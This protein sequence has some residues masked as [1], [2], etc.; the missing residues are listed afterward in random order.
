MKSLIKYGLAAAMLF[1]IAMPAMAKTIDV[2]VTG[3]TDVAEDSSKTFFTAAAP[4]F[5]KGTIEDGVT[6]VPPRGRIQSVRFIP[7]EA[8]L[9]PLLTLTGNAGFAT[10]VFI[11]AKGGKFVTAGIVNATADYT[12]T[13]TGANGGFPNSGKVTVHNFSLGATCLVT[14]PPAT[15]PAFAFSVTYP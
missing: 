11:F 4:F 10:W 5:T 7:P 12:Q 9:P 8:S 14:T 15:C 1:A 6:D 3:A 2:C 13:I